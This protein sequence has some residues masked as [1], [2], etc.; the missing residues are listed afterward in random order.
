M[1]TAIN[2]D[3]LNNRIVMTRT[4]A[5]LASDVRSAE[6]EMLQKARRDYPTFSVEVRTIKRNPNKET[7]AGLTYK[8][9][10]DYISTHETGETRKL[11]LDEFDE[12]L[13]ISKC[14]S[15]DFRYPVIKKWF[16][17]K[18]PAVEE[19]GVDTEETEKS[20]AETAETTELNINQPAA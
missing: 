20:A 15:K 19:F 11:V 12:M 13:L 16:L 17:K 8:Y 7:Y 10:R 3:F 4:F 9:M 2:V 1:K 6:Y 18:Y 14:H 5:K